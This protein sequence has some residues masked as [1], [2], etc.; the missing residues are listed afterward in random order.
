MNSVQNIIPIISE[1]RPEKHRIL[2]NKNVLRFK[3]LGNEAMHT[4]R[5]EEAEQ[6]YSKAI[7]CRNEPS[8]DSLPEIYLWQLYSNRSAARIKLGKLCEAFAD[9]LSSNIY[10]P[11]CAV[12]PLLRCAEA[13]VALGL[14]NEAMKLLSNCEVQFPEDI[15]VVA[16]KKESIQPPQVLIVGDG[17]DFKTIGAAIRV[18]IPGAE[19]IVRPG[20]YSECLYID[21]PISLCCPD[22]ADYEAVRSKEDAIKSQWAEI[23]AIGTHGIIVNCTSAKAL[24]IVGFQVT[25]HASPHAGFNCVSLMSGNAVLRNCSF[26]SSSGPVICAQFHTSNLTMQSCLVQGGAQGGILAVYGATLYLQQ[27]H[28]CDNAAAGL[29]VRTESSVSLES[30][31]FYDNGLQGITLWKNASSLTAKNCE[32]HSHHSESGVLVSETRATFNDCKFYGNALCGAVCQEKGE[33]VMV[34]C[35]V[36]S[37]CEGIVIQGNGHAIIDSCDV[38]SNRA[39]G[40]FV[41]FDH[42]GSVKLKNNK[43]HNNYSEGIL[44]CNSK[45]VIAHDNHDHSNLGLPPKLPNNIRP[46]SATIQKH[47]LKRVKKK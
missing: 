17:G 37:N 8:D 4:K 40:I 47:Y 6:F 24:H 12:K 15:S 29:E 34:G 32:I 9:S 13:M 11:T 3:D 46:E 39:N 20:I 36:F 18:A 31:R 23:R 27:V 21:K 35:E 28:C 2:R 5:Y 26:T 38:H 1:R 43:V 33:M 22:V 42:T 16:K 14:R 30:C 7:D 25:C 41:G 19:I 10:A 44:L 45:K